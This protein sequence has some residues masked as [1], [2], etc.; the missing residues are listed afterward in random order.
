M[1]SIYINRNLYLFLIMCILFVHCRGDKEIRLPLKESISLFTL[2]DYFSS[3]KALELSSDSIFILMSE[4]DRLSQLIISST[5][6]GTNNFKELEEQVK[7]KLIGGAVFLGKNTKLSQK[8]N[9]LQQMSRWPLLFS[10]DAEPSLINSRVTDLTQNFN[11]TVTT[12]NATEA[13]DISMEIANIL[14]SLG[15]HQNYAPVSDISNNVSV[16]NH[17]SYGKDLE[18]VI[19][20]SNA[21]I[22]EHQVNGIV[23]TAKHF[24]GHGSAKGDSH[25]NLVS[26]PNIK[27]EIDIFKSNIQNNVISI[28]IGHIAIENGEFNTNG[29]PS[30]ISKKVVTNLLRTE[31]GFKGIIIT[32]AMNMKGVTQF[33][34]ADI[35]ALKAG[36]DL[37]LMPQNPKELI[38]SLKSEMRNSIDFKNQIEK[39]IKRVI[40]LKLCLGLFREEHIN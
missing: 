14:S 34:D 9:H 22:S 3:N 39:S 24:P 11:K 38:Q 20:K 5:G 28:M 1:A 10:L 6:A 13:M 17:R 27:K 12:K 33:K 2:D 23:A 32:D 26:I 31:L 37:V 8:T 7:T 4:N 19:K 35:N 15:I 16:I 36:A 30:S 25:K 18:D 21:F 40:R 29:K